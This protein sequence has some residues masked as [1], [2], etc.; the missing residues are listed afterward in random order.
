MTHK[1]TQGPWYNT[2][3]HIQSAV[4]NEDNYICKAEGTTP[5]ESEANAHLIA[6]SPELLEALEEVLYLVPELDPY[7]NESNSKVIHAAEAAISKAKGE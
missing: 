4:I 7:T 2:N 1:H 3:G 5:E 6:A